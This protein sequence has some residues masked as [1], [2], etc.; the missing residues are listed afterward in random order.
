VIALRPRSLGEVLDVGVTLAVRNFIGLSLVYLL[1]DVILELINTL[2]NPSVHTSCARVVGWGHWIGLHLPLQA[3]GG[4]PRTR[5]VSAGAVADLLAFLVIYPLGFSATLVAATRA[6][7]G[8]PISIW[9]SY[10]TAVRRIVPVVGVEA[11]I[12]AALLAVMAA[13]ALIG[14]LRPG[15][16]AASVVILGLGIAGFV[17][18]LPATYA[19]MAVL[20]E[21][22]RLW[23]AL[24]LGRRR[25]FG[26]RFDF[27]RTLFVSG[28]FTAVSVTDFFLNELVEGG[29]FL[30]SHSKVVIVALG[31]VH[32]S[33]YMALI[34]GVSVAVWIDARVRQD[35]LDIALQLGAPA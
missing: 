1:S 28:F 7:M 32:D 14:S 16:A 19:L 5:G 4:E 13:A 11:V 8:S 34:A 35:G 6:A 21:E 12:L 9:G 24:N 2:A 15:P 31:V 17:S 23:D 20:I 18:I 22:R 33:I 3:C 26:S 10:Q 27:R 30:W 25:A 29:A